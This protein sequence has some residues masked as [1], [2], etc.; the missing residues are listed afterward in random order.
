MRIATLPSALLAVV[1]LCPDGS[2]AYL[3]TVSA[4]NPAF[5]QA[6]REAAE[7]WLYEPATLDGRPVAV[8]I[9]VFTSFSLG[10]SRL[11]P[12]DLAW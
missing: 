10:S 7:Q 2:V 1:L 9:L 12:P 5:E 4:T 8:R 6:S 3:E 11:A